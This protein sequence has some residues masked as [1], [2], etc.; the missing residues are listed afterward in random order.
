[1]AELPVLKAKELIKALEKMGFE[2]VRQRGSHIRFIIADGRK[3][4]V[5]NHPGA[6]IPKGLLRKI[7][8]ED[9]QISVEEF[10]TFL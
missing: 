4:T 10:I 2:A 9:L 7:I 8:R 1:M 5:P 6:D 3:T